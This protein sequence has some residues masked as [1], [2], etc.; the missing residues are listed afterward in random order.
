MRDL[1][2]QCFFLFHCIILA[3]IKYFNYIF[4]MTLYAL[5]GLEDCKIMILKL[6]SHTDRSWVSVLMNIEERMAGFFAG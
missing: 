5:A 6:K 4:K 2:I 3:N 1:L